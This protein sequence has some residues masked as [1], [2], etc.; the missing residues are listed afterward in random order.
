MIRQFSLAYPADTSYLIV[1]RASLHILQTLRAMRWILKTNKTT[2]II[3]STGVMCCAVSYQPSV[4]S[5]L[6]ERKCTAQDFTQPATPFLFEDHRAGGIVQ[7]IIPDKGAANKSTAGKQ[8]YLALRRQDP[9]I[10]FGKGN[11][12]SYIGGYP[13]QNTNWTMNFHILNS[14]T[15]CQLCIKDKNR[16]NTYLDNTT[17]EL[18][19]NATQ[20]A[21]VIP[22]LDH[23]GFFL[24]K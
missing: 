15:P 20:R 19:K 4:P 12:S 2:T 3:K 9:T 16:L 18:V 13:C 24:N 10:Q 17:N 7:K 1:L 6:Q 23:S 11:I 8:Q 22:K 14:P 21:S 5:L